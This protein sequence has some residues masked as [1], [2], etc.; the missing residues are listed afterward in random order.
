MKFAKYLQNEVVPEWRKA[1]LNYKQGKKYLKAIEKALDQP[2]TKQSEPKE[3]TQALRVVAEPPATDSLPLSPPH[4]LTASLVVDDLENPLPSLQ[5][6]PGL[7]RSNSAS[8]LASSPARLDSPTGTT[9][10]LN[11]V[12]RQRFR[13]YDSIPALERVA[14]RGDEVEIFQGGEQEEGIIP[15]R[16]EGSNADHPSKRPMKLNPV[17]GHRLGQLGKPSPQIPKSILHKINTILPPDSGA[18]ARHI[19]ERE[20][21]AETKLKVIKQQI[22]VANEWKRRNDER[23]AKLVTER[24]W[25]RTEWSKVKSGIDSLIRTDTTTHEDVTIIPGSTPSIFVNTQA[26]AS[27][28]TGGVAPG[29]NSLVAPSAQPSSYPNNRDLNR[30]IASSSGLRH[31]DVRSPDQTLSREESV[32]LTITDPATY[33]ER[34]VLEDETSQLQHM[35]HKVARTRIKAALYEFYRSLEMLKN[36]KIL[37]ITGFVKILKKF[38]KTAGWKASKAFEASK[39]KP[40]YFMS[41]TVVNDLIKETE[42]L[43]VNEF[44]KGHRRRGMAKLRIPDVK[45]NT[46]HASVARTGLYLGLA[47]PLLSQGLQAAFSSEKQAE[48][49]YWNSLL[50]VYGGLFITTLFACLFGIN[51]YVWAKSRINYKFIFEFDPRD[52]MDYHEF[53]ELPVFFMLVLCLAVY[54]DFASSWTNGVL[55][56]YW[57]LVFMLLVL[58]IIFLPLPTLGWKSRKW[59]IESF[60]RLLI[61]GFYRVEFRDF[62]LADELNSLSYSIEQFE[63][64]ICAYINQWNNLGQVCQTS[65]MWTTP[66]LTSLPPW[67]RLLQCLRRYRDTLEWFP[68]L[69]NAGKYTASLVNLFVY[70]S[71]RHYGGTPLKVAFIVMSFFT[72]CYTFLWDIYMDWGLFRFGKFG[73]AAYGR[74][75]LR[76]ELVYQKEWVYYLAIVLD[77]FGRFSWVVRLIPMNLHPMALPFILA[78]VEM[79]R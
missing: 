51:M 31:R 72:S 54:L 47:V 66:F 76:P 55:T 20:L 6:L 5:G 73:G 21:E 23:I 11:R 7:A 4:P 53:F 34:L 33:Q 64:A 16:G 2:L 15:E 52:N 12:S 71:Y 70:F 45:N 18:R 8:D 75:F 62:F 58:L 65:H 77:F 32:A 74:P 37:N 19:T 27:E 1:Y 48:I 26:C 49:P 25:Y 40:S 10:I 44:E 36:Y 59:F 14:A 17:G 41:S 35:N 78:M 61:S 67:L 68:H 30:N 50:L 46:H 43:F 38:D 60:S 79:L 69:L 56:A 28:H 24:G 22:Y 42:D 63:F 57:P 13:S 9:P 29:T 3:E 39:L